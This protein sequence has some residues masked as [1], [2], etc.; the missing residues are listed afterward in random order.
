MVFTRLRAD[1]SYYAVITD[2]A[3][4]QNIQRVLWGSLCVLLGKVGWLY[5]LNY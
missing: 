1:S 2:S 4:F 3:A 5:I